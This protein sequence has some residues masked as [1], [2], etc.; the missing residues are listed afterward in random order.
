MKDIRCHS[1][2][3]QAAGSTPSHLTV[4]NWLRTTAQAITYGTKGAESN[5]ECQDLNSL[6]TISSKGLKKCHGTENGVCLNYRIVESM[7]GSV[8]GQGKGRERESDSHH[9]KKGGANN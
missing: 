5:Q 2:L 7:V 8:E 3:Q 6:T 4:Q 1:V 9:H